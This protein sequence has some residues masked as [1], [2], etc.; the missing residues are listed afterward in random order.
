MTSTRYL[1]L[2]AGG[3]TMLA[4]APMSAIYEQWTWFFECFVAVALIVGAAILARSLRAAFW[5]QL[6][7]MVLT[8]LLALTLI[9]PSHHEILG[10]IPSRD[11]FAHFGELLSQ[12]AEDTRS[13]GVPVPD[14]ASLLFVTVL[15]VGGVAIVVDALSVGLRRPALAGL[16]MLAVYSV[17]V[18]VLQDAVNPIPF[19]IGVTGFLW[20]LVADR[21]DRVRRF[22][23]RFT[24]DGRDVDTWEPSPLA[25]AGRRLAFVGILIAVILPVA[26][27]GM[28]SG[29]IERIGSD[30]TGSGPGGGT[31]R[32]AGS[33]DLF[34]ELSDRL[35]QSETK[36]LATVETDDPRP[37]YLRIGIAD[38]ISPRGFRNGAPSGRAVTRGLPDP[39]EHPVDGITYEEHTAT[40]RVT[41]D[42]D[43]PFLPVYAEPIRTSKLDSSWFYDPNAVSIFSS[44]SRSKNKTYSFEFVRSTYSIDALRA[45][46]P[47]APDDPNRKFALG[48][49]GVRE[50]DEKVAELTSGITNDY[51]RVRAIYNFFSPDNN[52]KYSLETKPGTNAQAIVNFLENREGFCEQYAAAMA[53]LVRAAGIPARV[54]FGFTRG[55][56]T[57]SNEYTLTNRNL[58]A[59][60]EVYFNGIGWVPFDATPTA[61]V[62]GSA[63]S[64]WAPD[65]AAPPEE[66]PSGP[67]PEGS[68]G[69]GGAS[70]DP[71]R[72]DLDPGPA[73]PGGPGL[74]P[75]SSNW[76]WWTLGGTLLILLILGMP[77]LVRG[78]LR[79]RRQSV[80]AS[81]SSAARARID[82]AMGDDPAPGEVRVLVSDEAAAERARMDAHAAWDELLDTLVDFRVRV[83]ATETPRMTAQRLAQEQ[84][85]SREVAEGVR[86][87]GYA[88]ER[89]RYARTPVFGT[90]L[91]AALRALRRA[92]A[93]NADRTTRLMA[94]LMPPSVLYRWR[95]SLSD[96]S[97]SAAGALG[98]WRDGALRLSP[99]R[100]LANRAR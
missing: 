1:G 23:R 98:R 82:A 53:W 4:T 60:T 49:S 24:G 45:A 46:G 48:A 62:I 100:L 16:P 68:A 28:T 17:P 79:R 86:L 85:L 15:G 36:K 74:R 65:T 25:A 31:R 77:A 88:E 96:A 95:S 97:A 89:A 71:Q 41:K 10:I 19:M 11:T 78:L 9:F 87:L 58:H 90:G 94:L 92:L 13:Y 7:G 38:Q 47:L 83:D 61:G 72:K 30:G 67:A 3:A 52:F 6:L 20:L 93:D 35:N 70:P 59:W 63:P 76:P 64:A 43:M 55:T 84:R 66:N 27:P 8:L 80:A 21:V 99:R 39:R 51:D 34:A 81:A 29:L 69:A 14:R 44:R 33:V 32:G 73:V 40:V 37:Y 5:A 50:V 12:S 18:A 26:I 42:F 54:A 2:V 91:V 22:G 57:S 56:N 75:S